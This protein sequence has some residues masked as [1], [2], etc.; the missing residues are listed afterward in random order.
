M[1]TAKSI[2]LFS[3][4]SAFSLA[5]LASTCGS[6]SRIEYQES[7]IEY[8]LEVLIQAKRLLR[9]IRRHPSLLVFADP[10]LEEVGLALQVDHIHPGEGIFDVPHL[11]VAQI[12]EQAV[13]Q[14]AAEIRAWRK[15][16]PYKGKGI[17]YKGE[18]IFR[19]EGKKK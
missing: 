10:L 8:P 19:K 13:G 17:R 16:E 15:P 14:V 3:S 11:L 12:D 18:F 7:G 2:N 4:S 6:Q 5:V 1:L 9:L